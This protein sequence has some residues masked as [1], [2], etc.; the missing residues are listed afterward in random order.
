[1]AD[2]LTDAKQA[3]IESMTMTPEAKA[4]AIAALFMLSTSGK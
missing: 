3:I 1:M 2:A 4:K